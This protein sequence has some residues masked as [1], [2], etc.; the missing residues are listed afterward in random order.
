MTEELDRA[1]DLRIFDRLPKVIRDA[2]RD[3]PVNFS[4]RDIRMAWDMRRRSGYSAEEFA[5]EIAYDA[6]R[7]AEEGKDG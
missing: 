7:M 6:M 1:E 5:E 3:A 2:L 4:A